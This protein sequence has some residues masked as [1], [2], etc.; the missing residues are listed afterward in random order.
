MQLTN[1][2]ISVVSLWMKEHGID[3]HLIGVFEKE[4]MKNN[5]DEVMQFLVEEAHDYLMKE[6]PCYGGC[7]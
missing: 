4:W 3:E 6:K 2:Q 7:R 5:S 1:D